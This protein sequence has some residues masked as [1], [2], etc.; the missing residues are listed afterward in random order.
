MGPGARGEA[1]PGVSWAEQPAH[2]EPC[3]KATTRKLIKPLVAPLSHSLASWRLGGFHARS[4]TCH[5]IEPRRGF[6][7]PFCVFI[8]G[9]QA[10]G[11]QP[12]P[13][14]RL[15]PAPLRLVPPSHPALFACCVHLKKRHGRR[16][17]RRDRDT[18]RIE[19][20]GA[21]DRHQL[22]VVPRQPLGVALIGARRGSNPMCSGSRAVTNP[23]GTPKAFA[24]N[25]RGRLARPPLCR[26]CSLLASI[27]APP[28]LP[29]TR[30]HGVLAPNSS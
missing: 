27:V 30:Y 21:C 19:V 26:A 24:G 5:T 29:L 9:R 15:A 10:S 2:L 18:C 14:P 16:S 12:T 22:I 8:A 3:A 23:S 20:V 28:R 11:L 4:L 7:P 17:G 6:S 13:L 25:R 1:G